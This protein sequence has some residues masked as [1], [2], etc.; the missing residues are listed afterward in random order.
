MRFRRT[1]ASGPRVVLADAGYRSEENLRALRQRRQRG[2][3]A[4]GREG[5]SGAK[6]PR[7]CRTQ[8]MHRVLRLPWARALYAHRKTQAERPFAEIKQWMRFGRFSLRGRTKVRGESDLVYAALNI[9]TIW[10]AMEA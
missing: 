6:W 2:L 9:V 1:R 7:G 5:K 3:V 10:R 8:R 4:V